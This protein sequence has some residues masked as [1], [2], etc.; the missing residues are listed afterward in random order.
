MHIQADTAIRR[1]AC[2][3]NLSAAKSS[4]KHTKPQQE[5]DAAQAGDIFD[6]ILDSS[7]PDPEKQQKRI[8]QE[9]FVVMAAGVSTTSRV[10][11]NATYYLLADRERLLPRLGE[12]LHSVMPKVDSEVNL[13]ALEPLEWL[14]RLIGFSMLP[15][16]DHIRDLSLRI[17]DCYRERIA[18][19]HRIG[20]I[21]IAHDCP[22]SSFTVRR[23]DGT[24]RGESPDP[25]CDPRPPKVK[26][27]SR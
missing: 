22:K 19:H 26:K 16:L 7:L 23:M 12:E 5:A 21:E 4:E 18:P 13:K 1:H 17:T 24:T 20:H 8:A 25:D 14:V 6:A 9:G 15:Y 27:M 10:L 3:T 2:S 11:A